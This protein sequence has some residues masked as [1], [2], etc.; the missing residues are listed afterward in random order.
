MG[1]GI[2]YSENVRLWLSDSLTS[3]YHLETANKRY[4][5]LNVS[6]NCSDEPLKPIWNLCMIAANLCQTAVFYWTF[7]RELQPEFVQRY[8]KSVKWCKDIP[9]PRRLNFL[10]LYPFDL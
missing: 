4:T 9:Y 1:I 2:T 10:N 6:S 3:S 7:K 5:R 8:T